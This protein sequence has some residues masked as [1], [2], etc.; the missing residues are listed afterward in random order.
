MEEY[1]EFSCLSDE[2]SVYG[3]MYKVRGRPFRSGTNL[4]S[5]QLDIARHRRNWRPAGKTKLLSHVRT[6]A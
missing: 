4:V 3:S 1:L 2:R 6:A 5:W